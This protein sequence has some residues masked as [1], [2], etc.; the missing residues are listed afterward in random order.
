MLY[1]RIIRSTFCILRLL[2]S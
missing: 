2:R 1:M